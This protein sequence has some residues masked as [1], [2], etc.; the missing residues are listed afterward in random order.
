MACSVDC[1]VHPDLREVKRTF[2]MGEIVMKTVIIIIML[3]VIAYLRFSHVLLVHLSTRI[4]WA[5]LCV[6]ARDTR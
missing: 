4:S 6:G 3:H 2:G 1:G 5:P